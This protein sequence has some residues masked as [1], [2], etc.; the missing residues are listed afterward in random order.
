MT[1]LE[2]V[3]LAP[4]MNR[5]KGRPEIRIGLID[6]PI[7]VDHPDLAEAN[8]HEVSGKMKG[9]CSR[10]DSIACMHGTFV[11]GILV[12]RRGSDAPA[13]CPDCSL[14]LRPIFPEDNSAGDGRMP[15]STPENLAQ[16]IVDTVDAG[17]RILN[18]SVGLT[19]TSARGERRL[20]EA[21]DHA[22]NR[23]VITVA[24]AGNQAVVGSSTITRHP[25]V[26]PVAACDLRGQPTG[27]SNLGNSIGRR[28]LSAPGEGVTSLGTNGKPLTFGGTSTAAPFVSGALA[29]LWS[30]FPAAS[31]AQLRLA[32]G[33]GEIRRRHS[34]VPP[35]LDAWA[36]YLTLAN[37]YS[38]G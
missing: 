13:I 31:A 10:A 15:S 28:G 36:A 4:L 7:A 20:E 33:R 34:I 22:A 35:L 11:A 5:S 32:I 6:G 21:L 27:D 37:A 8:V 23:G 9:A 16:A 18:M 19:H 25:G 2:L 1:L 26:V 12:A 30:E 3:K 24:A 14:M 38:R 17:A 29:L